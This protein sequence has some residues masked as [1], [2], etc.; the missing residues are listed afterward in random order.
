[1]DG[2]IQDVMYSAPAEEESLADWKGRAWSETVGETGRDIVQAMLDDA[3]ATGVSAYRQIAQRFPSGAEVPIEFTI[4]RLGAGAGLVAIGKNLQTVSDLE[5]RLVAAQEAMERDYW[6][7]RDIETR[8]RLLF[9]AS[10]EAVLMINSGDLTIAEANPAAI[11]ALGLAPVGRRLLDELPAEERDPFKAMLDRV[12]ETGKS[13]GTLLHLGRD[14]TAWTIR[15]SLMTSEA[16]PAFLLQ[17]TPVETSRSQRT[18]DTVVSVNDLVERAPEGFV[19]IDGDGVIVRANRAFLDVAQ[20]GTEQSAL[21][22]R[23]GKWLGNPGPDVKVLVANVR[24]NGFV[25]RF[26]TAIHGA[27]GTEVPVE[28]SAVGNSEKGAGQFGVWIRDM[29]RRLIHSSKDKRPGAVLDSLIDKIGSTPLRELVKNTTGLIE[30]HYIESALE[31][32]EGNRTAAAELLGLSRQSLH[33][34]LNLYG[35]DRGLS[36]TQQRRT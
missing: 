7:L 19:V 21:G 8:Y 35:M 9:D 32:T 2:V 23:L 11:R 18:R 29:G 4:I 33:T 13:P 3:C 22:E 15:A 16:G 1:M 26:Q 36:K 30:R 5:M 14:R 24:K 17:L 25:R 28:V 31:M 10:S 12:R 20:L 34:K 27:L 6:K